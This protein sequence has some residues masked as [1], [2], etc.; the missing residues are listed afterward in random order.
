M[1]ERSWPVVVIGAGPYGLSIAAHLRAAGVEFRIFG[2]PMHTWLQRMPDG[3][4]LKSDGFA[5]NLSDPDSQ[6]TLRHFCELAGTPYDHTKIPVSLDTFRSYGLEFQKRMVPTLEDKQ[7]VALR[8]R[9]DGY[10]VELDDGTLLAGREVVLAVGITHFH[11]IPP[12]FAEAPDGLVSHASAH[13]DLGRFRGG[14]VTVVG[15]GASAI[16]MATLLH[17]HGA[18]VT[19]VARRPVRINDPPPPGERSWRERLCRPSST[20]GPGWPSRVYANA[21]WLVHRLP[22]SMRKRIVGRQIAS[23]SA[24]WPM[25]ARFVGRVSALEGYSVRDFQCSN[26]R[27]QLR[28]NGGGEARNHETEHVIAATGYRVDL[29]RLSFLADNLRSGIRC[30]THGPALSADFESSLPGLYFVGVAAMASFGP[31]M[32]FACGADWTAQ[33]LTRRIARGSSKARP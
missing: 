11:Y 32:R 23:P 19:L 30:D 7:V 3:M 22:R 15:G 31:V 2:S 9:S 10:E 5:S 33:Q 16:D 29:R 20:I 27:M 24:G 4:L 21:P 8:A 1:T 28:L 13:R 14:R 25:K 17:E 6:F 18:D 26:G 12:M